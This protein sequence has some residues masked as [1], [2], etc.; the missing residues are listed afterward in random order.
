M[1]CAAFGRNNNNNNNNNIGD[2]LRHFVI[3]AS[4]VSTFA[5]AARSSSNE[6]VIYYPAFIAR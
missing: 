6:L 1:L 5:S 3:S 2:G 4:G